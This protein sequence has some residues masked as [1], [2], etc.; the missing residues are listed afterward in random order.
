[1]TPDVTDLRAAIAALRLAED[2]VAEL[3][4]E[5]RTR[6]LSRPWVFSHDRISGWVDDQPAR[7]RFVTVECTRAEVEAKLRA[8]ILALPFE[9]SD[10]PTDVTATASCSETGEAIDV[11]VHLP[12]AVPDCLRSEGHQWSTLLSD[13]RPSEGYR[14][15]TEGCPHC[16]GQRVTQ[17]PQPR[18]SEAAV[19]YDAPHHYPEGSV[20]RRLAEAQ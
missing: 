16:D 2:R 20:R 9:R 8:A 10:K 17:W 18:G 5:I 6:D 19:T 11:S 1:M 14:Q 12:Q 15:I 13:E 3:R 7:T 4:H